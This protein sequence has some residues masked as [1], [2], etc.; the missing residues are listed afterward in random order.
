MARHGRPAG[1][2]HGVPISVKEHFGMAGLTQNAGFC[3][4]TDRTAPADAVVLRILQDAG[5]IFHARTTQPQTLMHLET[6]SNLF[7]ATVN[8]F[9]VEL[10]AGGSSGGEGALMGMRGSCL[11]L[12]TDIGGSV[13]CPAANCGLY[14]LKP[15]SYRVPVGGLAA[16]MLGQEHIVSSLGAFS[17]SLDGLRLLMRTVLEA[18]PWL[19]EPSLVPMP[20]KESD[21]SDESDESKGRPKMERANAENSRAEKRLKIAIMWEDGVVRPHPPVSRALAE[22]ST[23]LKAI[24]AFD[25]VDWT[26]YKHDLAWYITVR[27]RC[28]PALVS[29]PS[30]RFRR[31]NCSAL[32]GAVR[33]LLC[34]RGRRGTIGHRL[35]RRT[36]APALRLHYQPEPALQEPKRRRVVG[37]HPPA[38]CVPSGVRRRVERHRE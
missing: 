32:I 21:E 7:G 20:W 8:P 34:R 27:P 30:L 24:P 22:L 3:A 35:L 9:N 31:Q 11:G 16:T 25:V 13:R 38:R 6:A 14:G 29:V 10:T 12:G 23:R 28:S 37:T 17:T 36:L 5:A 15:T 18:K 33:P 4:W 19:V 2:L 1:P 26:P